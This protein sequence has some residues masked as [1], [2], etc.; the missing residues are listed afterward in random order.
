MGSQRF[1]VG[2]VIVA[3]ACTGGSHRSAPPPIRI[4]PVLSPAARAKDLC[5]TTVRHPSQLV[6]SDPTTI[7]AI[8]RGIAIGKIGP[9]QTHLFPIWHDSDFGAWCWTRNA[10]RYEIYVA[11]PNGGAIRVGGQQVNYVPASRA[12]GAPMIP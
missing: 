3:A 6:S 12:Y 11:G 5:R 4:A 7:G 8:R 9:P 2:I 1:V 10:D